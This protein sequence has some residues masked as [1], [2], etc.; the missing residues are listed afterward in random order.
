MNF[1]K[2]KIVCEWLKLEGNEEK[3]VA[4][5]GHR[6]DELEIQKV[7]QS[8]HENAVIVSFLGDGDDEGFDA[9]FF[10]TV[11][12]E[13]DERRLGRRARRAPFDDD[14]IS[15]FEQ[16]RIKRGG[17]AE[18]GGV[19]LEATLLTRR[20][21]ARRMYGR[22]VDQR[23]RTKPVHENLFRGAQL[24]E[25]IFLAV[26]STVTGLLVCVDDYFATFFLGAHFS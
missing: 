25:F 12:N 4:P 2:A 15:V 23:G 11:S 3:V 26:W 22:K 7:R 6:R 24:S 1:Q 13:L 18:T 8:I 16:N 9:E 5:V 14:R 19:H 17:M 21:K 10:L 20:R